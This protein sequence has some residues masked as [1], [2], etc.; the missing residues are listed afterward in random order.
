MHQCTDSGFTS[1]HMERLSVDYGK[2]SRVESAVYPA[3][4]TKS[5]TCPCLQTIL[6]IRD[7][8]G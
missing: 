5:E 3:S 7:N 1:L 8:K 2:K 6:F 4:T